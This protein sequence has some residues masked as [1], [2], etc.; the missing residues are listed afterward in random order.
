MS[1][2]TGS[3]PWQGGLAPKHDFRRFES[4]PEAMQAPYQRITSPI[5]V[6]DIFNRETYTLEVNELIQVLPRSP[7]FILSIPHAG[8]FIPTRYVDRFELDENCL[9]E[10]DLFSDVIYEAV[11]GWQLL[12]WLAPFFVDMNRARNAE[13]QEGLPRHLTNPPHEYY[14]VRDTPILKQPYTKEEEAEVLAYYD[15]YHSLL[16]TLIEMMRRDRGYAL[17]IDGHSM[18]AVGQGRVHDEGEPR[19]NFV[20]GTLGDTSAHREIIDAFVHTLRQRSEPQGLGLTVAKNDP[21]SGGFITRT[22]NDPD[23]HVHVMQLEITMDTYMYEAVD[24]R[25]VRRYAL[26]QPRVKFVRDILAAAVEAACRAADRIY[27]S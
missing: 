24:E 17:V 27:S 21:Y 18:T 22:H 14:T 15:L 1:E 20:V 3:I 26:K 13:D 16:S 5:E 19:D 2:R 8:L 12:C 6:L 23:N 4:L 10:I 9:L 7:E 25:A 11:G